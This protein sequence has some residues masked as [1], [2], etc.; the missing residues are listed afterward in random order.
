MHTILDSK[1]TC[2]EWHLQRQLTAPEHIK[3]DYVSRQGHVFVK[4]GDERVFRPLGEVD[5]VIF[6]GLY[7]SGQEKDCISEQR[8][9]CFLSSSFFP[10]CIMNHF[11]TNYP[12]DQNIFPQVSTSRGS[13]SLL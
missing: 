9:R 2:V 12:V 4:A 3:T 8:P 1:Q 13:S 7:H 5:E 6:L 11:L 10:I